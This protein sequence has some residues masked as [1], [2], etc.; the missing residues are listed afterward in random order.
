MKKTWKMDSN[1]DQEFIQVY[2]LNDVVKHTI[3]GSECVC[4]PR[5]DVKDMIVIHDALDG[6]K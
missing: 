5:I 6:R 4:N 1:V 2:P 3:V